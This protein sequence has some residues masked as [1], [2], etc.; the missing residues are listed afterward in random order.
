ML[1][2]SA[3]TVSGEA[4]ADEF[5]DFV[6]DILSATS[7]GDSQLGIL[8]VG[9][10]FVGFC[11]EYDA[12]GNLDNS[13]TKSDRAE[14]T[15]RFVESDERT[16]VEAFADRFWKELTVDDVLNHVGE[17]AT[18]RVV[19][20]GNVEEFFSPAGIT[21]SGS[22]AGSFC[23]D[24]ELAGFDHDDWSRVGAGIVWTSGGSLLFAY[25]AR[26]LDVEVG[27][28]STRVQ[29]EDL[30]T[31]NR[32]SSGEGFSAI[33]DS[34]LNCCHCFHRGLHQDFRSTREESFLSSFL[35]FAKVALVVKF[36][37]GV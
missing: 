18:V 37:G 25:R 21:R 20:Q 15:T 11:S 7:V 28:V 16:R 9:A 4:L 2:V 6:D 10:Q 24:E 27:V 35:S 13:L 23:S 26:V 29:L 19:L 5:A 17:V 36:G 8:E 33:R 14:T 32:M 30:C 12:G 1:F 22:S 3:R 34:V 31:Q